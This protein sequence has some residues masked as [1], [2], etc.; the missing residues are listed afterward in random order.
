MHGH[1]RESTVTVVRL[2]LQA[3]RC[4]WCGGLR[5]NSGRAYV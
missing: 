4:A 3:S 2:P 1:G 5:T